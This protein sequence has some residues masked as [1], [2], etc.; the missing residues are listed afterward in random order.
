M[1][2][3]NNQF[4]NILITG[5]TGFIGRHLKNFLRETEP[6][7]SISGFTRSAKQDIR[8]YE[9]ILE[10]VRGKELAINLAGTST[11]N[12]S[13][14][15]PK[16]T[17][18]IDAYGAINFFKA[19]GKLGIPAIHI[20]SAEVYGTNLQPGRLMSENHPLHP[21]HPYGVAKKAAEVFAQNMF[22]Q[23][24]PITVLRLFTQYGDGSS[25]PLERFV[26]RL[27]R[28]AIL[29][30]DLPV[31][32]DGE[33]IRDWVFVSDTAGAIWASRN[34]QP[35]FYN[36]CTGQSFSQNQVATKIL[37]AVKNKFK[38]RSRLV[39]ILHRRNFNETREQQGDPSRFF[40]ETGWQAPTSL[41]E[42]I[43]KCIKFY[44]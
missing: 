36:I 15:N 32:G 23:G 2:E 44:S 5:D 29:G 39:N 14:K 33:I 38:T 10:A 28:N 34:A 7:I 12:Y 17:V 16:Q 27:T 26:P 43:E 6:E 35:G 31:E 8:N 19:C 30:K 20:S 3:K 22:T 40:E 4:K 13:W 41:D 9:Q 21:K 37:H 25:E 24:Q 1:E 42:G 18:D 11:V